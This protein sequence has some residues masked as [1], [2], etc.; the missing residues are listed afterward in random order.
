MVEYGADLHTMDHGSGFPT[1][2]SK[3]LSPDDLLY[4]DSEW[5]LNNL[6]VVPNSIL[7]QIDMDISGMKVPW[8]YVWD[9]WKIV[10]VPL[11]VCIQQ[12]IRT[13]VLGSMGWEPRS[14]IHGVEVSSILHHH[15]LIN[16]F[17]NPPVLPLHQGH[18]YQVYRHIKIVTFKLICHLPKRLQGVLLLCL[19]KPKSLHRLADLSQDTLRTSPVT[20]GDLS[21][22]GHQAEGVVGVIT[23][24]TEQ[25]LL[26]SIPFTTVLAHV[27]GQG[28]VLEVELHSPGLLLHAL[29]IR[30][31]WQL[32][33]CSKKLQSSQFLGERFRIILHILLHP[34]SHST[35]S[36]SFL[37]FWTDFF[38]N[39][40][41]VFYFLAFFLLKHIKWVQNTLIVSF[42]QISNL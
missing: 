1:H 29:V 20:L 34:S 11:R 17:Q 8:L 32:R 40:D 36:T 12:V 26:L 21:Q 37:F 3:H 5:N 28:V 15:I 39:V 18:W 14:M 22:R 13:E 7:K 35:F 9:D 33:S 16:I 6:P 25:H 38:L 41:L 10:E 30:H 2:G 42:Q 31:S 27:L 4:A 24:I 23:T 19:L